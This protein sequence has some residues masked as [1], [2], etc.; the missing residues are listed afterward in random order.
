MTRG[1]LYG[2]VHIAM[3]L[4]GLS[5]IAGVTA[6][7][8]LLCTALTGAELHHQRPLPR[9]TESAAAGGAAEAISLHANASRA[10]FAIGDHLHSWLIQHPEQHVTRTEQTRLT[11]TDVVFIVMASQAKRDRIITQRASWMRWAEYVFVFADVNDPE[12]GLITL[13]ELANKTGFREAQVRQLFG[14]QW[15]YQFR[16]DLMNKKWF[17][18]VDDDTWVNV[19]SLLDYTASFPSNL[20]LS[21]SHIY[22]RHNRAV[23]NGGAGML[24]SNE[25]FTRIAAAL[26]T[27]K[28]SLD[29][30]PPAPMNN[31]NILSAC[32]H[33]TG[34]L[35][36]TSSKFG[37]Y[38]GTEFIQPLDDTG[39]LDQITMHKVTNKALAEVMWCWSERLHGH[40]VQDPCHNIAEAEHWD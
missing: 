36:V 33:S 37:S 13:P 31:D 25:A 30:V 29:D 10:S 12:L 26:F 4:R 11:A 22:L 15:V 19:P 32:A 17:F 2:T 7:V 16:N 34:V 18:L 6:Y 21:F 24:F 38:G 20:P 40:A 35:K 14:M 9:F 28:C 1:K 23:Y 8:L 27:Q 5:W 39:W 3:L